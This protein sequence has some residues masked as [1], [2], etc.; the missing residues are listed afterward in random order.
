MGRYNYLADSTDGF[1]RHSSATLSDAQDGT[2]TDSAMEVLNGLTELHFGQKYEPSNGRVY[3]TQ[4]FQS[5]DFTP[6]PST[7][8]VTTACYKIQGSPHLPAGDPWSAEVRDYDWGTSLSGTDWVA[9]PAIPEKPLVAQFPEIRSKRPAPAIWRAG[10]ATFRQRVTEASPLRVMLHSNKQR[11]RYFPA[12]NGDE[13]LSVGSFEGASGPYRPRIEYATTVK[14]ALTRVLPGSIQLTDGTHVYLEV[15]GSDLF[16]R[17]DTPAAAPTTIAQIGIGLERY[18][19]ALAAGAQAFSLSRDKNNNLFV[20]GPAG[21]VANGINVQAFAKGAGYSWSPKNSI[22][23]DLPG[24]DESVNQVVSTW[25]DVGTNG[26]LAVVVAHAQGYQ[27]ANQTVMASLSCANALLGSG[28]PLMSVVDVQSS[29]LGAPI[30]ATGNGL[31]VLALSGGT[32]VLC[33]ITFDHGGS[34]SSEDDGK[35][36]VYGYTIGGNGTFTAGPTRTQNLSAS[37]LIKADGDVRA[38]LIPI[39]STRFVLYAASYVE[40][41]S[42]TGTEIQRTGNQRVSGA[43]IASFGNNYAKSSDAFYD[44]ASNKIWIYYLDEANSRRL[45]RTSYNMATNLLGLDEVEVVTNT[46]GSGSSNTTVRVPRGVVDERRVQIHLGNST[47][48]G[49]MSLVAVDETGLNQAPNPPALDAVGTF[50]ASQSRV[51]S[52]VFSDNNPSDQQSAFQLQ[53]RDQSSGTVVYDSSKVSS[54]NTSMT[55]A[56]GTLSNGETYEWRVRTYDTVDSVSLY[57]AYQSFDTTVTGLVEI[58]EPAIDNPPGLASPRLPVSWEFTVGGGLSQAKYRITVLRTDSGVALFD[59]G[60]IAGPDVRSYTI[61]GLLTDVQQQ[62]EVRIEDSSGELSNTATR[63]VTPSFSAPDEPY[64]LAQAM[65]DGS[66]VL[67]TTSNPTPTGDLP[68][69]DRNDIYRSPANANT[70]VK[71]GETFPNGTFVDYTAANNTAYD[72]KIYAVAEGRSESV[73][74]EDVRMSFLGVYI[75]DPLLPDST[76]RH[77]MYAASSKTEEVSTSSTELRFVGRAYPV[78]EYGEQLA[79]QVK[80]SID[81]PFDEDWADSVEYLRNVGRSQRVHCYRDSRGRRI[82][83]VVN[84]VNTEDHRYGS[85]VDLNVTRVDYDEEFPG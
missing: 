59:T 47:G 32:G 60:Y 57:S 29:Y 51:F 44:R 70:Y 11:M 3:V 45:M 63:L 37:Y 14:S 64:L 33:G 54:A 58:T 1:L 12:G 40:A 4:T 62:I 85:A 24:Y 2:G 55:L 31:D 30:N 22:V 65:A 50:S 8:L 7:E 19:F 38:K 28:N 80:V 17:H 48:G 78:Y 39:S 71:I 15:D 46:G 9:G 76:I 67:I 23:A 82:F 42:M 5:Y 53:I 66:G 79:E 25:H 61:Q 69:A 83:G 34:P 6:V 75:H 84:S 68:P 35:V 27:M 74:V 36:S 18:Q 16:L 13:W 81:V 49:V 20:T 21:S 72:Y 52:W 73:P 43:G 41:F 10:S 56:A 77:F 26:Y